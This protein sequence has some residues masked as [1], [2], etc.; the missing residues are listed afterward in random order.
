LAVLFLRYYNPPGKSKE[1]RI[2]E[3]GI[4]KREKK[5]G[6]LNVIVFVKTSILKNPFLTN[7]F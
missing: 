6:E 5:A 3:E 2:R 4:E 7:P 1:F